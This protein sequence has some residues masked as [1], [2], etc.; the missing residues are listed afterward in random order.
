MALTVKVFANKQGE[1]VERGT[2]TIQDGQVVAT[3]SD[4]KLLRGILAEGLQVPPTARRA[5]DDSD[6]HLMPQDN[7]ERFLRLLPALNNGYLLC[8]VVEVADV[9]PE[10]P[11]PPLPPSEPDAKLSLLDNLTDEELYAQFRAEAA[12]ALDGG[13]S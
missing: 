11:A 8:E 9:P 5:D 2:L 13:Q 12:A 10:P 6:R 4:D 3:P 1:M 7:P